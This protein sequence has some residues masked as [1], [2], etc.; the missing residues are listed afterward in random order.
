[1]NIWLKWASSLKRKFIMTVGWHFTLKM[2]L[3]KVSHESHRS[4]LCKIIS[5]R[6]DWEIRVQGGCQKWWIQNIVKIVFCP[7][8]NF[9]NYSRNNCDG[10]KTW[11]CQYTPKAVSTMALYSF[12]IK[13]KIQSN[14]Q[15]ER[16]R[17]LY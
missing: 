4:L 5:E 16:P 10:D 12:T 8:V 2:T 17:H 11:V 14:F 9:F 3:K 13:Q 7:H 1:M 6:I 15:K